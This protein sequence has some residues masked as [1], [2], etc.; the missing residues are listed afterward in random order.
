[1]IITNFS[2]AR[3]PFNFTV[4]KFLPEEAPS[5]TSMGIKF[6]SLAKQQDVHYVESVEEAVRV[7]AEIIA[8]K[9]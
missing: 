9:L 8:G 5:L 4:V 7:T 1:M 6:K 2:D 3:H